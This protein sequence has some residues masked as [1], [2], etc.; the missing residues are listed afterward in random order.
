VKSPLNRSD[1]PPGPTPVALSA[2]LK[3]ETADQHERMHALMHLGQPFASRARYARF[4]AAQ[5][6]FQGDIEALFIDSRLQCAVPDLNMRG[7][8]AASLAD[9]NDLGAIAPMETPA[10][11]TVTMPAALGWLYVA[12]GSTLGAAFLLKDAQEKLGLSGDFGARHLAS[13]PEG[14][15]PAWRRFVQSLDS[16]SPDTDTH[17][18]VIAGAHAAYDRFG[19]LLARF[20]AAA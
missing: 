15:M 12:E 20:F 6:V 14:R 3:T 10:T 11:H 9:L 16:H 2:R 13:Y 8:R 17:D 18:A 5:S 4:V 19:S 1:E 7:R